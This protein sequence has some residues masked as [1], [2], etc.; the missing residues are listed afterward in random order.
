VSRA[1]VLRRG[2]EELERSRTDQPYE[3]LA[4][5]VRYAEQYA[6]PGEPRPGSI[7]EQQLLEHEREVAEYLRRSS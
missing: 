6:R 2:L 3:R 5:L 4:R 1:E 7:E